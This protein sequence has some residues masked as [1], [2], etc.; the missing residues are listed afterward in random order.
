MRP[1]WR[2]SPKAFL[3]FY[4]GLIG[5]TQSEH[6]IMSSFPTQSPTRTRAARRC[7]SPAAPRTRPSSTAPSAPPTGSAL[8]P[9]PP[10]PQPPPPPRPAPPRRAKAQRR[11]G[12]SLQGVDGPARCL[13]FPQRKRGS[14]IV[15]FHL[16][17]SCPLLA[18][19]WGKMQ[20]F[21]LE[22]MKRHFRC[23]MFVWFIYDYFLFNSNRPEGLI[24]ESLRLTRVL[25]VCGFLARLFS[26]LFKEHCLYDELE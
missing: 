10:P 22:L 23:K 9:R 24:S 14:L 8:P 20:R 5:A 4:I 1:T 25:L 21:S 15:S 19:R 7:P 2:S 16:F 17:E 12:L 3:K 18:M 11:A 13:M 6:H 26:W